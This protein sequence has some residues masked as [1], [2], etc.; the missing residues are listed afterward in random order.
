MPL[1]AQHL[2]QLPAHMAMVWRCSGEA[3]GLSRTPATG[4]IIAFQEHETLKY[5]QESH[6][7]YL[8]DRSKRHTQ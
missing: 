4:D 8:L 2:P 3:V 5:V 6:E 1:Q 7:I